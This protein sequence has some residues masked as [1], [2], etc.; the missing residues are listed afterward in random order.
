MA[1]AI[2]KKLQ[3]LSAGE[4]KISNFMADAETEMLAADHQ[5]MGRAPCGDFRRGANRASNAQLWGRRM[6][7][8]VVGSSPTTGAARSQSLNGL[9]ASWKGLSAYSGSLCLHY[10]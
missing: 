5:A 10:C 3:D 8:E 9:R 7:K 1:K 4:H 2:T 6:S